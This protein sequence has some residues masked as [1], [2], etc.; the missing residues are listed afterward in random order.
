MTL[1][2]SKVFDVRT[3]KELGQT[4]TEYRSDSQVANLGFFATAPDGWEI[5]RLSAPPSTASPNPLTISP[6]G[7]TLAF[8]AR[9]MD[10]KFQIWLRSLATLTARPLEGTEGASSPFWSPDSSALGFFAGGKLKKIALS[11]GPPF[12]LADAPNERGG[13]WSREGMIVFAPTA[14]S[15]LMKVSAAGGTPVAV[16]KLGG[17]STGHRRPFFLPDGRHLLYH[18]VGTSQDRQRI[19]LGSIDSSEETPLITSDTGNVAY[20]PGYLLFIRETTLMAQSFDVNRLTLSGDPFPVAEQIQIAGY[21]PVGVFSLSETGVLAYQMGTQARADTE[22]T[23]FDRAGKKL[24]TLGTPGPYSDVEL[25]RDA[26]QVSINLP[27][28]TSRARDIWLFDVARNLRTRFTF[29]AADDLVSIWSPDRSRV[30]YNSRRNGKLDLYVK[31]ANGEGTEELLFEDQFDKVPTSWAPDGQHLLYISFGGAATSNDL[32]VLPLSGERKPT[33][34]ATMPFSEAPG[35]FS[36][37]GRWIAYGSNE[38]GTNE[39]YVAPFPARGG[40]WQVSNAGAGPFRWSRNGDEIVYLAPDGALMAVDV[41][42]RGTAFQVGAVK[43]LFRARIA[44]TRY[45]WAVTPDGQ[46]FLINT[47]PEQTESPPIT[48]V[49]NWAAGLKK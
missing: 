40:K 8:V 41:N 10:G 3:A 24:G 11:G 35:A 6:D 29:N 25:S 31:A 45:E 33:P 30:V 37:D 39:L 5:A 42:G 16:T 12:T 46:R 18:G 19:Y 26:K 1:A 27:D 44:P 9:S 17:P 47:P 36:P 4:E 38:S 43:P 22:L 14:N 21:P 23:W 15:P 34:F 20:A 28:Q 2:P 48:V 49:L 32:F 7:R 13:T